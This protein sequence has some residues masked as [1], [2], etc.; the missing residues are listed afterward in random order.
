MAPLKKSC[1]I[2][3]LYRVF[4]PLNPSN[5]FH[6]ALISF[7][8]PLSSSS[9][10]PTSMCFN[11]VL[12]APTSIQPMFFSLYF[13]SNLVKKQGIHQYTSLPFYTGFDD[14]QSTGLAGQM[15]NLKQ[16]LS[17]LTW[18]LQLPWTL[19]S[20]LRQAKGQVA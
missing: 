2:F 10:S 20:S 17:E 15:F 11:P 12:L 7:P 5:N 6:L 13:A 16:V 1:A 4:L 18:Q 8:P 14:L 9:A 19:S 3:L